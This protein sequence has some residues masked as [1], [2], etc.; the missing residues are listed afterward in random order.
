MKKY[1]CFDAGGTYLKYALFDEEDV[2]LDQGRVPTRCN[3][4]ELFLK[5][6][7]NIYKKYDGVCGIGLSLPGMIDTETGYLHTSGSIGCLFNVNIIEKIG[8]I[9]GSLPIAIENDANAA[10]LAEAVSGSLRDCNNAI[11]LAVGTSIGGGI[12]INKKVFHGRHNLAGEVA[13]AFYNNTVMP[14]STQSQEEHEK[15]VETLWD[16]RCTASRMCDI[17]RELTGIS[18]EAPYGENFFELVEADD[19]HALDALRRVCHDFGMLI[20]NLQC[21]FDPDAISIGGGISAQPKFMEMLR[22]ETDNYTDKSFKNAPDV[23]L[24]V[25]KY[26][27]D[28]NLLGA[29]Y[30]LRSRYNLL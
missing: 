15:S 11:V 17:Y 24:R 7:R 26:G 8:K 16:Y 19:L 3:D 13:F 2:F 6:I 4:L 29:L 22:E 28:A 25:C 21:A 10:A 20:F 5:D 27:N 23:D 12:I 18:I 14:E 9:C 1:L 30:T